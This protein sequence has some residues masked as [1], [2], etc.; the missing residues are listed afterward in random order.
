MIKSICIF[1][2]DH[3]CNLNP[4][5]LT[6]PV[7]DLRCGMSSLR[8]K[9][10]RHFPLAT[11][12]LH[13][14]EYLAEL[15]QQ[16]NSDIAVNSFDQEECLF[17]NGRLLAEE[18][19]I[20]ALDLDQEI[21]YQ[22]GDV[23]VAAFLRKKHLK[24]MKITDAL[25]FSHLAVKRAS[26]AAELINYPWDLPLHNPGQIAN[27][28]STLKIAPAVKGEAHERVTFVNQ[29]QIYIGEQ[30]VVAPGVVL[31]AS[32]GPIY[33]G[34]G[35]KV[36]A[37]AVLQGPVFIGDNATIKIAAK[38]YEGVSI[39]ENCKV[40]GEVEGS[41]IHSFSNKQHDGFLGHAY[42]GQWVNLGA[43]TNNSDLKNNYGSVTVSINGK[44]VDSGSQF[45]GLFMGDHS[46]SGINTM[47]NTGTVVGVMSNVYGAGFPAKDIPSYAWG[48]AENLVEHKLSKALQT[49]KTVMSR[50]KVTMTSAYKTLFRHLHKTTQPERDALCSNH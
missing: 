13:C 27:D 9:L 36:M 48:G 44:G 37:N 46:K 31:D 8:D 23:T 40:G 2:D 35:A 11:V 20:N 29:K 42:L 19:F 45:V 5:A 10:I 14:R 26:I 50:R 4:L 24:T 28:F 18:H 16:E 43:D 12:S 22:Q 25:S 6:R 47:F 1:E 39:G 33:I 15:T 41:I 34:N 21:I 32:D 38:I 30:T 17:L 3:A 49:A 7:Y